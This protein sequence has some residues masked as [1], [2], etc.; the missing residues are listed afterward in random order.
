MRLKRCEFEEASAVATDNEI[1]GTVAEIAYAVKENGCFHKPML[2]TWP[3]LAS[4][5]C[6]LSMKSL[7]KRKPFALYCVHKNCSSHPQIFSSK[8]MNKQFPRVVLAVLCFF[9]FAFAINA[10]VGSYA[11]TNAKIVTVSG[12][13]IENGTVVIRNGLIES[14]GAGVKAPSDAK[15]FDGKGMT[16]YPGLFDADTSLGIPSQPAGAPGGGGQRGQTAGDDSNSNYADGLRPETMAASKLK[17]GD[18]QISAHRNAGFTTALTV[19]NSGIF[20]GQ[21]AVINLAGDSVSEMIIRSPFAQH[22]TFT[23]LRG[24]YPGSL[25]GTFAALRQMFLDAKRH[26]ELLKMYAKDPRGMK[27]PGADA[28]L[29]ALIP[30]VNGEQ[31]VVFTANTEREIIR[32]LDLA[33]EFKLKALISGGQ[34]SWKVADRLKADN[35]A[36][37]LSLDFPKRTLSESKDAEPETLETL[38][39]RAE[40][41]KNPAR[42]KAAGV[43]FAFHSGELKNMKDYFANA[44]EAVEN[45]LSEG[46]AVRAMTLTAAEILG[47][48]NTLGSIEKGKIANL[49]LVKGGLLDKDASVAY[50][51]VD[52][53]E[54]EQPKKPEKPAGGANAGGAAPR[55]AGTW[56]LTIDVPGQSVASTLTLEQSAQTLTGTL[57]SDMFPAT[58]IRDGKTTPT[59]FT[60]SV[61]VNVGGS[62]IPVAFDGRVT[63]NEVEG[64]IDT[65]QGPVAFRGTRVP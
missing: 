13:V 25:L 12:A 19:D 23:T 41:P 31:P 45:G 4:G 43:R 65:P 9:A 60:F 33:K 32:A 2:D 21:S 44:R 39:L 17:A 36:V 15:I 64:T 50:V 55:V 28:S 47:V 10:Q 54:F 59:G 11:I 38:R 16:V 30:V 29:E 35:I 20:N 56:N 26:D 1:N 24:S 6:P 61:T 48:D 7:F 49:V 46:D 27:R 51:F 40:V 63:G 5:I 62:D 22:V 57:S 53:K 3:G 14:V 34:E 37:L 52:G 18:S 58:P 8:A 42:L